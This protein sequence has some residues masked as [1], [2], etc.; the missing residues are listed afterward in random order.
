MDL[1]REIRALI[2]Q[3]KTDQEVRDFL[4]SR[5]GDFVLYRP[6]VKPTTW[7]LWGG[8]FVLLAAGLAGLIVFLRKR[9]PADAALSPEDQRRADDLAQGRLVMG[10]FVLAAAVLVAVTLLLLLRPW[11]RAPQADGLARRREVNAGVY[12]DQLQELDRDLAAGTLT[13]DRPAQA[14]A[15]LQ[16]RLL[17]DTRQPATPSAAPAFGMRRTAAGAGAAVAAGHR[18][19]LRRG[20][21]RRPRSTRWRPRARHRGKT[22]SRWWPTWPPAL[23]KNPDDP[24]GWVVLARSYRAMGRLPRPKSAFE[25]IGE[26]LLPG[27]HPA[28]RIRRR[29]GHACH[30]QLRGQA[31]GDGRARAQARPGETAGAVARRHRRLQPQRLRAR[32]GGLGAPAAVL[33]PDRKTPSG[34]TQP[35]AETRA[36]IAGAARRAGAAAAGAGRREGHACRR[37]GV[38]IRGRVTL[39]PALAAKVQPTD[40]VFVFARSPQGSRMPLAVQRA[41]VADLPLDFKLDDSL[42]LSPQHKLSGAAQVRIEAR[43]SRSGDATPAA[44]DLIG[45][46]GLVRPGDAAPVALQIDRVRPVRWRAPM[47][48]P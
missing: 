7:L 41:S 43:I 25:R 27:R 1:R 10:G 35:L 23:E 22:S 14:R 18:R 20:W 31:D 12:R 15:E 4:V 8:P 42:A 28:G 33:P 17:D 32:R 2:K 11:R 45:T 29:A 30:G 9:Q 47:H 16:R 38:V 39:A 48:A 21:A 3:G 13:A 34:S 37:G 26:A 19:P 40:T 36:Q 44:G 6:P 24:K 5:Y 46:S